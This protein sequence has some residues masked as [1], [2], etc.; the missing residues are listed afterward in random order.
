MVL[1]MTDI[2][3]PGAAALKYHIGI[4]KSLGYF[5]AEH[6]AVASPYRMRFATYVREDEKTFDAIDT[7][8]RVERA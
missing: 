1:L 7:T 6:H 8:A 4:P 5:T 2:Y 3:R